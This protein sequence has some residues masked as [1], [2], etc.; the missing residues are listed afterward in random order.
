MRKALGPRASPCW[1]MRSSL[2]VRIAILC[3][4]AV[5]LHILLCLHYYK[6]FKASKHPT[7]PTTPRGREAIAEQSHSA[8][9]VAQGRDR[10]SRDERR[11]PDIA[12]AVQQPTAAADAQSRGPWLH[13]GIPTVPR[14]EGHDYLPQTVSSLLA[15]LPSESESAHPLHDGVRITVMNHRPGNHTA[16]YKLKRAA[17]RAEDP[18]GRKAAHYVSYVENPGH[19]QD[20]H[21][22]RS[23]E[24][25][26][27]NNPLSIPGAEVR[28]QSRDLVA[29]FQHV[30]ALPPS[31]RG[32]LLLLMED[33]FVPCEGM[34]DMVAR[35][36]PRVASADAQWLA[37]RIS[38]GMNG[39]VLPAGEDDVGAFSRYLYAKL[40]RLPPDMLWGEWVAGQQSRGRTEYIYKFNLLDHVGDVSSFTERADRKPFPGCH[41][42]MEEVWSFPRQEMFKRAC[43]HTDVSPCDSNPS[44]T[45]VR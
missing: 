15:A 22:G 21:P 25:D 42:L 29:L 6:L 16:F 39:I 20:R 10:S 41:G 32:D 14:R 26:D 23:V 37:L 11:P 40:A 8:N 28:Q 36:V 24:P 34:I 13:I 17:M 7:L 4:G 1:Q 45:T 2:R 33:D 3:A 19:L 31:A 44:A 38:Y 43:R 5:T 27:H 35:V 30:L 9:A 12:S 18:A